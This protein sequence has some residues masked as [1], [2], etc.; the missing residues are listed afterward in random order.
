MGVEPEITQWL[1]IDGSYKMRSSVDLGGRGFCRRD[2]VR[3]PVFT[4]DEDLCRR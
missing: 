4:H 2:S 1:F 3:G